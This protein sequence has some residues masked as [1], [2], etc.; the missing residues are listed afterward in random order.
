MNK[1]S[2][3]SQLAPTASWVEGMVRSGAGQVPRVAT[4]LCWRDWLGSF[5]DRKASRTL[6]GVRFL[7]RRLQRR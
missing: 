7:L 6:A 4:T 3:E 1:D 2:A 5:M